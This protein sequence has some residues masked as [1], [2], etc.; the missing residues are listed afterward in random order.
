MP[1]V[2]MTLPETTQ[3]VSRP[4]IFEIV[5]QVKKITCIPPETRIFFPGDSLKMY[6]PGSSID[7][8]NRDANLGS[9]RI[10]FIEVVE[11][12][13]E[14]GIA[15]AAVG[16]VEHASVFVDQELGVYIS[17]V[18][19]SS[20]VEINF[21]YRTRSKT[22][23]INWINDVEMRAASMRDVNVHG[24][25]YHY[26][27]PMPYLDLI[28]TVHELR[29]N[30]AGYQEMFEEYV[31]AHS[32]NRLT[33]IGD[34]A[35]KSCSL[36]ISE[37]QTKIY[38]RF[39]FGILPEKPERD[40]DAAV[41]T[42]S[43]TYKFSY[44]KPVGCDA[45][46]PIMVHNQLLP[47]EYTVIESPNGND[48]NINKRYSL[49]IGSLQFFEAESQ[50][51]HYLDPSGALCLPLH[52]E[53]NQYDTPVGTGTILTALC[54]L[55]PAFP[56]EMLG[57]NELGCMD[58][59]SDVLDF[60]RESEYLY[61]GQ[62]Y[63]SILQIHLY[64]GAALAG[65]GSLSCTADLK[66]SSKDDLS[67]RVM[68]RVRFAVVTDLTLLPQAAIDR[69]LKYPKV[70]IKLMGAVNEILRDNPGIKMLGD[71]SYVSKEDFSTIF[72]FVTGMTY[73]KGQPYNGTDEYYQNRPAQVNM[74]DVPPALS[75]NF[76]SNTNPTVGGLNHPL[77]P[78]R[79][80]RGSQFEYFRRNAVHLNS[81]QIASVL[82]LRKSSN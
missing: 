76:N 58:I 56:K 18:Y 3:S 27:L 69:L 53:F 10:I 5:E 28:K 31:V 45:K 2:S 19:V 62:F 67:L 35:N 34:L 73:G 71:R 74:G 43:F 61:I 81:L 47:A 32:S 33:L 51:E 63:Q 68:N 82:A 20:D 37:R 60:I 23:A 38:G 48:D 1:N 57:L 65:N 78:F 49:S 64:R 36:G 44:E 9:D 41:W 50:I 16:R 12:F 14:N 15:T 70:F 46:Y 13:N 21:K 54:E 79:G 6:Q 40:N 80:I 55:D 11:K 72:R 66:V 29:E 42:V 39:E 4:I 59:D 26:L 30:V 52:D 7:S 8:N 24:V 22:E 75:T 25:T 17:P 77:D